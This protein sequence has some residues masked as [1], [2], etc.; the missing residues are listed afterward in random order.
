MAL[1]SSKYS[2]PKHTPGKEFTLDGKNYRG[3]YITTY[4]NKHYTGKTLDSKS[5]RIYPVASNQPKSN[6]IFIEQPTAPSA[7]DK[8]SGKWT[9]Y[10]IQQLTNKK[11]IE[12]TRIRYNDFRGVSGYKRA[13]LEWKLKGPA[14]NQ[15]IN[16][17][18]YFGAAHV[19]KVNTQALE[20]T[21]KGITAY[22]K[23]YSEFVE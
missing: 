13:E 14:D 1:P 17:Y 6:L 5:K 7:S 20:S 4:Q 16:G 15:T 3:W 18:V 2:Q 10:F 19:N 12:V 8:S 22:I 23:D 9:R 21:I 11:I